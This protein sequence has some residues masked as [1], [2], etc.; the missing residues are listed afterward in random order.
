MRKPYGQGEPDPPGSRAGAGS[1]R[2]ARAASLGETKAELD[3]QEMQRKVT[4]QPTS[5]T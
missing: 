5:R 3:I 4:R 2:M 1:A